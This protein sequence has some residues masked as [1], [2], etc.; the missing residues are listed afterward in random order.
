MTT[1]NTANTGAQ[2]EPG[3]PGAGDVDDELSADARLAV[4]LARRT[5][6]TLKPFEDLVRRSGALRQPVLA[7]NSP[8]MRAAVESTSR[9]QGVLRNLANSPAAR[10]YR[11]LPNAPGFKAARELAAVQQQLMERMATSPAIRTAKEL[12]NTWQRIQPQDVSLL[13]DSIRALHANNR[14]A[15][16]WLGKAAQ[17]LQIA[18]R[19]LLRDAAPPNWQFD[20]ASRLDCCKAALALSL[21]EG[22]PLAWVPDPHTVQLLLDVPAGPDQRGRRRAVLSE[23]SGRVLNHCEARLDDLA[24]DS[25]TDVDLHRMLEIARQSI[26]ALR[27]GLPAPA[28]AAAANLADQLLRRLFRSTDRRGLQYRT[29]S[30]RIVDLAEETQAFLSMLSERAT[31]MPVPK[32]WTE[33]WPGRNIELP[34]TFSRHTTT[35]GIAEPDQVTPINALI[36][37]MLAVSLLYQE[38]TSGWIALSTRVWN[39]GTDDDRSLSPSG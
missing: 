20:D 10:L 3:K 23:R 11:D 1:D 35:H 9:V 7:V 30:Q 28:Q 31:L 18:T 39:E 29:A 15:M 21:E 13:S 22:I 16:S 32:S 24:T 36:A 4:E 27:A 25:D 33:W 5:G 8:G 37:I 38:T 12:L 14:T 34:D 17:T 2:D 26:H 6:E 19:A